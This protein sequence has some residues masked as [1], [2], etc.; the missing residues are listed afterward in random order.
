MSKRILRRSILWLAVLVVGVTARGVMAIVV[1]PTAVYLSDRRPASAITLYN[2]S[3]DPEEVTVE[4]RFGYPTTDADGKLLLHLDP[5]PDED[6]RSAAGW[7]QA[8]PRRLVVPPGERRVV[9]LLARPPQG[10]EDGE[11]WT[12]LM[13]TSRGQMI[14]VAGVPDSSDV[15]VGLDLEIRTVIAVT[16]RK[17]EVTTGLDVGGFE[18]R[19]DGDSLIVRPDFVRRGEGA[20]IGTLDFTLVDASG[21][22]VAAW[23]ELVAVYRE[24]RR[25]YAYDV[26]SLPAGDYSLRLRLTTEREDVQPTDRLQTAPLELSALVRR[27]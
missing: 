14:P 18:P 1:A 2:P 4:A 23:N 11:Y 17:G 26:S 7:I 21:S 9:R 19:I 27:R 13:L 12:R 3:T 22:E 6:P 20:Y 8:L 25:R 15:Q 5:G 16:F 10:L 24:Y